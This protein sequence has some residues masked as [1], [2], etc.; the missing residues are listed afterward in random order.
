MNVIQKLFRSSLGKKTIM[1]ITGILLFGFVI[2]HMLGNLQ[3]F[4]GADVINTY[5]AFL[6]SKP[7]LL[8][9]ARIGLLVLVGLHIGSA[10]QLSRQNR[11][12]RPIPYGDAKHPG[13]SYASR[14]M[15]MSGLIVLAFIIYH[16]LHF[17]VAVPGVNLLGAS[18]QLPNG[19]F[20][21]LKDATGHQ[22]V[23]RMLVLGFSNVW[24]SG[25]YIVGMALLCMHLSHG[26][27]SLFQSLGIR[28]HFCGQCLDR[29]A[30]LLAAIIFIGNSSIPIAILLG[31]GR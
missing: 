3:I 19:D 11:A 2:V 14:T 13:A 9:V 31:Y 15:L 27:S 12:A 18:A 10:V 23:F 6:K 22:D 7:A 25:F 24:V 8:W 1:A 26:I 28:Q 16:L 4:L 30:M 17:T 20:L 21:Q 29:L 5:A